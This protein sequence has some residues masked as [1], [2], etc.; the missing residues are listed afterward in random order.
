MSVVPNT[1][2]LRWIEEEESRK[3]QLERRCV[4]LNEMRT[5][6]SCILRETL[7]R[8]EFS[9]LL[10]S[11][12][13]MS[14]T[15]S[16]YQAELDATE[17]S[18]IQRSEIPNIT[19]ASRK[20]EEL[21]VEAHAR[22]TDMD[23]AHQQRMTTVKEAIAEEQARWN[24]ERRWMERQLESLRSRPVET[25]HFPAASSSNSNTKMLATAT[26]VASARRA[27]V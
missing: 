24:L 3:Q 17:R 2:L 20:S 14:S 19:A 1:M 15:V 4:T 23:T 18:W 5:R 22:L 16:A 9:L 11:F 25:S 26:A 21:L 6:E 7:Q 10:H 12:L 27:F 8:A 13:Q